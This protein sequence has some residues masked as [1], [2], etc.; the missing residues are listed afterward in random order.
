MLARLPHLGLRAA[1]VEGV[2]PSSA[3]GSLLAGHAAAAAQER[4]LPFVIT[5]ATGHVRRVLEMTG[6][7]PFLS[8]S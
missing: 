7:Y 4:G 1:D 6:L 5:N 8:A 2:A 3:L